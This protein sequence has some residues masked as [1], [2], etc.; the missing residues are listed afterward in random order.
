[1]IHNLFEVS[2]YVYTG[3]Q[4]GFFKPEETYDHYMILAVE[5]G[6]FEYSVGNQSGR[7]SFGDLVFTPPG[8]IFKRKALGDITFHLLSFSARTVMDGPADKL[9]V[10][11]VTLS[12]VNRLSSTYSYLR[13]TYQNPITSSNK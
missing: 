3:P 5:T 4:S 1:M 6:S 7:A 11:K 10:G 12:N 2:S 13:N 9:P 8:T